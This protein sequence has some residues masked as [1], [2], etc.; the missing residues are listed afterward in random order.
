MVRSA[1]IGQSDGMKF[2][3]LPPFSF[4]GLR[5]APE[6]EANG[7]PQRAELG[8]VGAGNATLSTGSVRVLDVECY[9]VS[10]F[11]SGAAYGGL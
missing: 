1:G 5:I 2:L 9:S 10:L 11:G 3:S 8:A 4:V 7:G 6:A